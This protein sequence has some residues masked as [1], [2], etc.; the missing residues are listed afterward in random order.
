MNQQQTII[1]LINADQLRM[2]ALRAVRS[3]ALPDW[4]IAAGFVRN[5]VWGHLFEHTIALNDID[6]I[7]FCTQDTTRARDNRLELRLKEL[8]PDLPWSV[9]NQARMHLKH[10]DSAYRNSQD[11]MRH[12]PEKQTCIGVKLDNQ[13]QL[14]ISHCFDLGLQF[15]G[16]IDHNPTRTIDVF[17]A[18]IASKGWLTIWPRLSVKVS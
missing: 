16:Q 6:V 2:Q 4:L 10:G 15:S 5:M 1:A 8:V 13:N 3:L 18:R 7:Y 11:A 12:W 17:N 14:R 9:N